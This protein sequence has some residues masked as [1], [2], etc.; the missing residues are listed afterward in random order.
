MAIGRFH[1]NY[2]AVS[3]VIGTL[4]M[5]AMCIMISAVL[6]VWALSFTGQLPENPMKG[7][8]DGWGDSH[9]NDDDDNDDDGDGR[10]LVLRVSMREG[11]YHIDIVD[12]EVRPIEEISITLM[13]RDLAPVVTGDGLGGELGFVG[14]HL[15]DILY[16]RD[17]REMADEDENLSTFNNIFYEQYD[18]KN[19]TAYIVYMDVNEDDM[20][21]PGDRFFLRS[22][23]DGGV[24][25]EGYNFRVKDGSGVLGSIIIP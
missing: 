13:D 1:H 16:N 10:S 24:C 15:E 25:G 5:V 6:V 12:T 7:W 19:Y 21:N 23:E 9:D 17:A 14:L 3:E 4:L 20:F 11:Y 22:I 8:G 18:G 2:A